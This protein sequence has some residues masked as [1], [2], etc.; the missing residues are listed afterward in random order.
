MYLILVMHS[1]LHSPLNTGRYST[2]VAPH[3]ILRGL[4]H[5]RCRAHMVHHLYI[6]HLFLDKHLS[7]C[8]DHQNACVAANNI[9]LAALI[10]GVA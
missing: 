2:A 3:I 6:D 7:L 8:N 4:E 10:R 5:C 9:P 1:Y